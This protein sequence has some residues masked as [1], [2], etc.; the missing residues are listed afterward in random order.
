MEGTLTTTAGK[1]EKKKKKKSNKLGKKR[2]REK[3]KE[4][5]SHGVDGADAVDVMAD[6]ARHWPHK[7]TDAGIG[8]INQRVTNEPKMTG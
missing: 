7:Y 5:G 3:K 1:K 8:M 2:E 4:R 6:A